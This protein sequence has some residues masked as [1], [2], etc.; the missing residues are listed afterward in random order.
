MDGLRNTRRWLLL[1]AYL[2][3]ACVVIVLPGRFYP[4]Y[5]LL[6]LPPISV[7]FGWTLEALDDRARGRTAHLAAVAVGALA[8]GIV[9]WQELPTYA[10]P[11][12]EWSRRKYGEIFI[13][14]DRLGRMLDRSLPAH[15]TFF[16]VGAETGLYFSS[17]RSPPSGVLYDYPL[18]A[19]WPGRDAMIRRV[20]SD[21][22]RTR[23]A[24]IV[25][26]RGRRTPEPIARW[27]GEHYA[28]TGA[29]SS[30]A[31]FEVLARRDRRPPD[32]PLPGQLGPAEEASD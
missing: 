19:P 5:F 22:E 8:L 20:V 4:H 17:R 2:V 12:E 9:M 16:E 21:L 13:D 15:E 32:S 18:L 24:L 27:I 26:R 25:V 28:A 7:G 3:S 6:L 29:F 11:A 30:V 31:R 23:P 1:G 10:L 14:S